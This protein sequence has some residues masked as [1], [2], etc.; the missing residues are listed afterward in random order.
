MFQAER[1][2]CITMWM[3]ECIFPF[4]HG[5]NAKAIIFIL[6]DF[7]NHSSLCGITHERTSTACGSSM[8]YFYQHTT[9][10]QI[11]HPEKWVT[12][13]PLTTIQEQGFIN[14]FEE[15]QV[16][17]HLTHTSLRKSL[18]PTTSMYGLPWW[19]SWG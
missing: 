18:V 6:Q 11:Q 1:R 7:S 16:H 4:T 2:T 5:Q 17:I 3:H 15:G 12:A 8:M 9:L 13:D 10:Q 19:L 14:A